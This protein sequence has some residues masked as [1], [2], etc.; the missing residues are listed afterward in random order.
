[1]P[2]TSLA[3]SED[4]PMEVAYMLHNGKE[5]KLIR[6]QREIFSTPL[7][8]IIKLQRFMAGGFVLHLSDGRGVALSTPTPVQTDT[9][10][11]FKT[12][13][14]ITDMTGGWLKELEPYGVQV[15]D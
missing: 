1:M 3:D 13:Q 15:V 4:K 12:I 10:V 7:T 9:S 8:N 2:V 5:F 11:G 6:E 14:G